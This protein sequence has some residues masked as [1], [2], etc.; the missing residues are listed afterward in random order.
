[1]GGE[2]LDR[3]WFKLEGKSGKNKREDGKEGTGWGEPGAKE[4]IL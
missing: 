3:K 1:M 4:V 2:V